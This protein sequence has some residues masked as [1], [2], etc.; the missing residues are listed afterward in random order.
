MGVPLLAVTFD[1][2]ETGRAAVAAEL[3]S[4][5][6]AVHPPGLDESSRR[7]ALASA[8]V[9]L[10]RNTA[11]E[12]RAGEPALLRGARLVQFLTAGVDFIPLHALPAGVPVACN[13]GGYAEPMAERTAGA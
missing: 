13:G 2:S 7:E 12:L 9:L 5:A 8:A 1:P 6:E 4:S 10:A 11:T 3:G